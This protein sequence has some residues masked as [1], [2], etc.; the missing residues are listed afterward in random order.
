MQWRATSVAVKILSDQS[1][2][3]EALKEFRTELTM[4]SKMRHPNVVLLMGICTAAAPAPRATICALNRAQLTR[5]HAVA[6]AARLFG[7]QPCDRDG[8]SRARIALPA[9]ASYGGRPMS[10]PTPLRELSLCGTNV[11]SLTCPRAVC[12]RARLLWMSGD[13]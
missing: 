13:G 4:M 8:V 1:M 2:S 9:A 3:D 6:I 10:R 11:G 7:A 5:L 12:E